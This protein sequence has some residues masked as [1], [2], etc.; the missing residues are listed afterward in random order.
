MGKDAD[1]PAAGGKGGKEGVVVDLNK[2]LQRYQEAITDAASA[3]TLTVVLAP[4][5]SLVPRLVKMH[6]TGSERPTGEAATMVKA[7]LLR[8]I[9]GFEQTLSVMLDDSTDSRQL[10][11]HLTAEFSRTRKAAI[12]ALAN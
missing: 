3:E 10:Y 8:C 11:F 12:S 9:D 6:L 1:I 7:R 2:R 5:C 4:L